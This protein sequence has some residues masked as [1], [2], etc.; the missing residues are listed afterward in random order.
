MGDLLQVRVMAYTPDVAEVERT[1]PELARL[2][3]PPGFD[4]APSRRGVLELAD[5][6]AE[7]L[8]YGEDVDRDLAREL[9]PDAQAIVSLKESLETALGD[10]NP[11]EANRLSVRLENALSDLEHK[12]AS[13]MSK[14]KAKS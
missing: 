8:R 14:K 10:W 13:V 5:A 11:S 7:R 6:L 4:Y 3:W 9:T 1:W 12:A 2:A